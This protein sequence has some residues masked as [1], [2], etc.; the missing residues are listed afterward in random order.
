M[1]TIGES[2]SFPFGSALIISSGHPSGN[3]ASRRFEVLPIPPSDQQAAAIASVEG[4]VGGALRRLGAR[5][6]GVLV[7]LSGG[8]DSTVLAAVCARL[9]GRLGLRVEALIVDHGLR[10][11]GGAEA[12]LVR[13]RA[14]ALGLEAQVHA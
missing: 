5:G 8:A 7:A 9:A 6:S 13:E 2:A 10:P 12:A 11:E 4:A 1:S 3:R 14:R